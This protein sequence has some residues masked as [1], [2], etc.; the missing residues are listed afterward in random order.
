MMKN[1]LVAILV[2][3]LAIMP[4]APAFAQTTHYLNLGANPENKSRQPG[5]GEQLVVADNDVCDPA[6]GSGSGKKSDGCY[7]AHTTYITDKDFVVN[8]VFLCGNE[9]SQRHLITGKVVT[10]SPALPTTAPE[11]LTPQ[12][13]TVQPACPASG[14]S[15]S[16]SIAT[17]NL[18]VPQ[19]QGE[20]VRQQPDYYTAPPPANH[21]WGLIGVI[22]AGGVVVAII[23]ATHG[24]STSGN[25]NTGGAQ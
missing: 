17:V 13:G 6:W 11:N 24:H 14:C 19:Q 20:E 9:P 2:A 3:L 4:C 21:H 1:L 7:P 25:V 18:F 5:V 12:T 15:S 22:V 16:S 23:F 8:A 10:M